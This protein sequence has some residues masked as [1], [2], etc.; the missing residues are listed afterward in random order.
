[1]TGR[2]ILVSILWLLSLLVSVP[3]FSQD[4]QSRAAQ[5]LEEMQQLQDETDWSDAGE[6][7]KASAR[8]KELS[9]EYRRLTNQAPK[10]EMPKKEEPEIVPVPQAENQ[11][12]QE[13]IPS[14]SVTEEQMMAVALKAAFSGGE[15]PDALLADPLQKEIVDEYVE[16]AARRS[17]PAK[18]A[19]QE[20]LLVDF[21]DPRVNELI[22]RLDSYQS[23][24][25]LIITGGKMKMAVSLSSVINSCRSMPLDKLMIIHCSNNLNSLPDFSGFFPQLTYLG[26]FDNRLGEMPEFICRMKNLQCLYLDMN[27]LGNLPVNIAQLKYLKE[28]G[29]VKTRV[30]PEKIELLKQQ[31]PNCK[32]LAE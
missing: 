8:M 13:D 4:S 16:E 14:L 5:V 6:A 31:M 12:Y 29:L 24:K 10:K 20:I 15:Y 32:I 7:A 21:S 28:L 17:M 2:T 3:V 27:P 23:V 25:T 26:L 30:P 1:M 11:E 19:E 22:S 18:M 9:A